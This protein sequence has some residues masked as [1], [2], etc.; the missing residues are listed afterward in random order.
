M[1][2]SLSYDT[3]QRI[4]KE[5][6]IVQSLLDLKADGADPKSFFGALYAPLRSEV[7]KR[8]DLA[9]SWDRVALEAGFVRRN[10]PPLQATTIRYLLDTCELAIFG[11][12]AARFDLDTII[13]E[14]RLFFQEHVV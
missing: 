7:S 13:E 12:Q 2:F 8:L 3:S 4:A 5:H 14:A 6:P 9:A 1:L 11:G 10:L